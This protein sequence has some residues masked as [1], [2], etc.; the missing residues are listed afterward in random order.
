MDG[1]ERIRRLWDNR[2]MPGEL[3][4]ITP[5]LLFS[6]Y[7]DAKT[8]ERTEKPEWE[9]KAFEINAWLEK[10]EIIGTPYVILDDENMFLH[11]QQEHLVLTDAY[12]GLTK[13]K[14]EKVVALLT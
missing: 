11:R 9:A 14:A 13:D 10:H 2:N 1:E 3:L 12:Y 6:T 7:E 5:I 8:K 4:G